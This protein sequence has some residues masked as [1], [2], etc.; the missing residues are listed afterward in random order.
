[1]R[2]EVTKLYTNAIFDSV[3]RKLVTDQVITVST[4]YGIILDVKPYNIVLFNTLVEKDEA[5]GIKVHRS[6]R[7]RQEA[8]MENG[9]K[10]KPKAQFFVQPTYVD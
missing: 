5:Q 4:K 10:Y 7:M 3:A 1:M 8:M 2:M 6:V 9:K